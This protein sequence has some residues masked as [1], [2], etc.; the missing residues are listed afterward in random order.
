MT[1]NPAA[2]SIIISIAGLIMTILTFVI[3]TA[4]NQ[5]KTQDQFELL[6]TE[7]KHT[8]SNIQTLSDRVE[9]HNG[10]MERTFKLEENVR[11]NAHDIVELK[12]DVREIKNHIISKG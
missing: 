6:N 3:T 5:Q 11:E 10:V 9:K 7:L 8:N 4:K 12:T 2:V 1:V